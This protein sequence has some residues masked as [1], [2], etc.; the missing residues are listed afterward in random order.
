MCGKNC[1]KSKCEIAGWKT[2]DGKRVPVKKKKK[3]EKDGK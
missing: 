2:V 3:G 1:D